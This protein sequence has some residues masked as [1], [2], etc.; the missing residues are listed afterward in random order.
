MKSPNFDFHLGGYN[1][2]DRWN[3]QPE[4]RAACESPICIPIPK[5]AAGNRRRLQL[6]VS[7][8]WKKAAANRADFFD[9]S[10]HKRWREAEVIVRRNVRKEEEKIGRARQQ[11]CVPL[12]LPRIW[13]LAPLNARATLSERQRES[14][15][16]KAR[17][18][19]AFCERG[20]F[21]AATK[22]EEY[23]SFKC[24]T[25][26]IEWPRPPFL[27]SR[28][29]TAYTRGIRVYGALRQRERS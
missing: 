9:P 4:E 6:S 16:R 27:E 1:C 23:P 7:R 10:S 15:A 28:A 24:G 14:L 29:H 3:A 8:S 21:V 20:S 11:G 18:G 22:P 5:I 2:I 26:A 25:A 12:P 17:P 19:S 13:N